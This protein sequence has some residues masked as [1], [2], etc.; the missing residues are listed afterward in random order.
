MLTPKAFLEAVQ[1]LEQDFAKSVT[2]LEDMRMNQTEKNILRAA[3]LIRQN[4]CE[5]AITELNAQRPQE[6]LVEALK[7]YYLGAAYNHVLDLG[8]AVKHLLQAQKLIEKSDIKFCKYRFSRALFYTYVNL[9]NQKGMKTMLNQM[10]QYAGR[11]DQYSFMLARFTFACMIEDFEAAILLMHELA[12]HKD[13]LVNAQIVCYHI[14]CFDLKIKLDDHQGALEEI[15][16]LKKHRN[17]LISANFKFMS[18]LLK[19]FMT[20][21]AI[22]LYDK[23]FVGA[24]VL[25]YQLKVILLLEAQKPDE[26]LIFW[27]K[28]QEL[29]SD[30]Y[31]A[32]FKYAGDKCLFSICLD[33]K[34]TKGSVKI[35][36]PKSGGL[37]ERLLHIL[38][39]ASA[40]LRKEE[41]FEALWGK[42]PETKADM[43]RLSN[44]VGR[45]KKNLENV[46]ILSRK[47]CYVLKKAA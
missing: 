32:D 22:Y 25:F 40:P 43:V 38:N 8:H 16:A 44:L 4:R 26:A 36:A 30:V 17:Y 42:T 2:Y 37:E 1:Y 3:Q 45:A 10:A 34:L 23:D 7:H 47:G 35:E 41:L 12:P 21:E 18:S 20:G 46:E 27:K 6:S 28:L 39:T 33:Q 31:Q 29:S 14:D 15:E 13:K 24:P 11:E 19:N 5:E 9:K